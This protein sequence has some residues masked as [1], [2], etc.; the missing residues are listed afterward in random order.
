MMPLRYAKRTLTDQEQIDAFLARAKVGSLGLSNG[1]APYIIPL[2]FCWWRGN[3]YFH[4]ADSGRKVEMIN[5]NSRVCFSVWEEYGTIAAPV[6]AHTDTAYMSVFLSGTIERVVDPEEM[7]DAMQAMLDKYVPGYYSEPLSL[8]HVEKYRSSLGSLTAVFR[9]TP[10]SLTAKGNP[11]PEE[12]RFYPGR[13][14][15]ADTRKKD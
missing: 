11:L 8:Q 9:I 3:I 1:F 15:E 5:A 7:R 10:D 4:G 14:V 13:T 12:K 2:N 6:P